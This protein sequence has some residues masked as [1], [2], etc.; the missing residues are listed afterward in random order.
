MRNGVV[1]RW[2][3]FLDTMEDLL[4]G[5]RSRLRCG[6]GHANYAIMTD[7]SI[8]PCPVMIGMQ[9][10][11]CGHIAT[12]TPEDLRTIPITGACTTCPIFDFCGGRCLYA[13]IL[14]PW[15]D[16]ER[17]MVCGTVQNLHRSLVSVIPGIRTLMD[18]GV[19]DIS[20]FAHE[21]F[22]GCEIIP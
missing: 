19:I 21:K 6:S 4:T 1:K 22:N 18:E 7:G 3:P 14:H 16:D 15:S 2:Y 5:T 10:F 8:A 9:E 13:N 11:Y 20:C 12:S 17:S